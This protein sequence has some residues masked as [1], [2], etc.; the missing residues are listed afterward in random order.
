MSAAAADPAAWTPSPMAKNM[1][2]KAGRQDSSHP[3]SRTE[4]PTIARNCCAISNKNSLKHRQKSTIPPQ[5]SH[6]LSIKT[7]FEV[8][9]W[10]VVI[11]PKVETHFRHEEEFFL[12]EV[13]PSLGDDY[14]ATLRQIKARRLPPYS[15]RTIAPVFDQFNAAGASLDQVRAIFAVSGFAVL[16]LADISQSSGETT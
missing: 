6:P 3:S 11:S 12:I 4:P 7:E 13:K 16:S 5:T 9:G 1:K 14:P 8:N 15:S 10:D 2:Q